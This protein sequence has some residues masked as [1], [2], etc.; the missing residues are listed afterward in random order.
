MEREKNQNELQGDWAVNR[1][2]KR[3]HVVPE[4][5]WE[6][7]EGAWGGG[8]NPPSGRGA[9]VLGARVGVG[10][11]R[12][13][14]VVAMNTNPPTGG[15]GARNPP[16]VAEKPPGVEAAGGR[17][18]EAFASPSASPSPLAEEAVEGA[19]GGLW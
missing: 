5:Y 18:G 6:G 9:I 11:G 17:G 8:T 1:K 10:G 2:R 3:H 16:P 15:S 4:R 12:A 14:E 19:K 7:E 13:V